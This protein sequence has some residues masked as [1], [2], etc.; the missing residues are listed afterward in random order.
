MGLAFWFGIRLKELK[1]NI[2]NVY[3]DIL[4]HCGTD[5]LEIYIFLL[6][7]RL[8]CSSLKHIHQQII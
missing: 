2:H 5:Y 6:N 7:L 8:R 4:Y 1:R 3:N